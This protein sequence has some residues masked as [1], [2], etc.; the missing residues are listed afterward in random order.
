MAF[1]LP[2]QV[3]GDHLQHQSDKEGSD[4]GGANDQ[5]KE[6]NGKKGFIHL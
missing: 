1:A 6:V 2:L 3:F 4:Q 5:S